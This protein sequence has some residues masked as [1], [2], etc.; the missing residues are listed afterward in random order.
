MAKNT[1][2]GAEHSINRV[3]PPTG[4]IRGNKSIITNLSTNLK[5]YAI[6][7]L[8]LVLHLVTQGLLDMVM[9]ISTDGMPSML[10]TMLEQRTCHLEI[11]AG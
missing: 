2:R 5:A 6:L 3:N 11:L 10:S 9:T 1:D 4:K 8:R 7:T